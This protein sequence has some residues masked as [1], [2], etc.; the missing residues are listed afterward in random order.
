MLQ[1][2]RKKARLIRSAYFDRF[3]FIHINKTGGSSIEKAL[4]LP[5]EHKT[6]IEKIQ[7]IGRH[8]WDRRISFA[9]VRNP[10]DKVV[11]HYHYRVYTNQTGM[12]DGH[13]SFNDWVR[14]SYGCKDPVYYD[15]PKMFQPQ[16]EWL[17]DADSNI[18]VKEILR[19]ENLAGDFNVLAEKIG[20][21]VLLPHVKKTSHKCYKD[22]YDSDAKKI[23]E[24][25]FLEDID[26]FKY[27]F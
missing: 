8:E 22:Y 17:K 5:F 9:V 23:I 1:A 3:V 21:K 4:K 27:I 18:C 7:E 2:L 15:Q 20:K 12:G 13:I 6:A 24:R 11:S 25:V 16:V 14:R 19:F 10:W 26:V